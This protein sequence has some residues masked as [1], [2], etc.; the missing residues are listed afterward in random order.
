MSRH[1]DDNDNHHHFRHESQGH[2]LNLCQRLDQR[3]DDAHHHGC[4]NGRPRRNHRCPQRRL[5]Q[6]KCVG[7]I[8]GL[9]SA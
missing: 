4:G 1:R 7:L 9:N 2:F 3:D 5:N 8:H 6:L